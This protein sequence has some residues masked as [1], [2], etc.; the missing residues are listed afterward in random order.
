MSY[1]IALHHDLKMRGA[2][3][4]YYILLAADGFGHRYGFDRRA[5][6][7]KGVSAMA[8]AAILCV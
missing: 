7:T 1:E 5:R 8:D 6:T 2:A 3:S 4:V